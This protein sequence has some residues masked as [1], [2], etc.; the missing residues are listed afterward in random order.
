M[1]LTGL[2]SLSFGELAGERIKL[3]LVLHDPE[4]EHDCFSDDTHHSYLNSQLGIISVWTGIMCVSTARSSR[5]PSL[6]A[7]AAEKEP[8]PA[9]RSTTRIDETLARFVTVKEEGDKPGGQRWDQLI[10]A[11]NPDGN[12][13]IQGLVDGLVAQTRALEAVIALLGVE[14]KVEGS[15]SLKDVN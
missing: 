15:D 5:V 11:D 4:E 12:K 6:A 10:G 2:G 1:I 7:L 13:M 3:G 9:P 8:R 14:V